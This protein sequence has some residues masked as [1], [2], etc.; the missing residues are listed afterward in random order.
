MSQTDH[1][2]GLAP[3]REQRF[4][5]AS[6]KAPP[7]VGERTAVRASV[8]LTPLDPLPSQP[9]HARSNS[10]MD[11]CSTPTRG[12]KLG[13]HPRKDHYVGPPETTLGRKWDVTQDVRWPGRRLGPT[14]PTGG[15][16]RT[17]S[18][19]CPGSTGRQEPGTGAMVWKAVRTV[20]QA[21]LSGS[22]SSKWP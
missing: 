21:P 8:P 18:D 9:L 14:T 11:A 5:D 22:M 15:S 1:G 10:K 12:R 4:R 16:T 6:V 20:G 17:V 3:V 13:T 7:K 2:V 19:G